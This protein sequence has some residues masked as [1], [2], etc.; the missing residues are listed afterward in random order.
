MDL[1][2]CVYLICL[3]HMSYVSCIFCVLF[4]MVKSEECMQMQL[5]ILFHGK[6]Y[7]LHFHEDDIQY[8]YSSENFGLS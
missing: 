8:F 2:S 7:T 3:C 5:L 4:S 1:E 6:M